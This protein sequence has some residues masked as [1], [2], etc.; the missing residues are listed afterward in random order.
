[1]RAILARIRGK[2]ASELTR[3]VGTVTEPK[4]VMLQHLQLKTETGRLAL[5]SVPAAPLIT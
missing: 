4:V 2:N 1:V 3:R 5:L